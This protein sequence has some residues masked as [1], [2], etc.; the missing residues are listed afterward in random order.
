MKNPCEV[1]CLPLVRL[2]VLNQVICQACSCLGDLRSLSCSP[3]LSF[4]LQN[5]PRSQPRPVSQLRLRQFRSEGTFE[6]VWSNPTKVRSCSVRAGCSVPCW[7]KL[8]LFPGHRLHYQHL[9]ALL[10]IFPPLLSRI[11]PMAGNLL[12][13]GLVVLDFF[14]CTALRGV[15]QCVKISNS[16][17]SA[18]WDWSAL[19]IL[20]TQKSG[21]NEF[22]G[23]CPCSVARGVA[24]PPG[25]SLAAFLYMSRS[26]LL[27][28][29]S[30][31]RGHSKGGAVIFCSQ[32]LLEKVQWSMLTSLKMLVLATYSCLESK[33]G[34][35]QKPKS[36]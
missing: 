34:G 20:W 12:P 36:I 32:P 13:L 29:L 19:N 21:G 3:A 6:G 11:V 4:C 14:H 18:G 22:P 16:L 30:W 33:W 24:M 7:G 9:I 27:A 8:W 2:R 28:L 5:N 31:Q 35:E 10:N 17:F 1:L 15:V 26:F 25:L 23:L